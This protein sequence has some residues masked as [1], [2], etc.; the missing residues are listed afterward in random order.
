[1]PTRYKIPGI[2]MLIRWWDGPPVLIIAPSD[3]PIQLRTDRARGYPMVSIP[4]GPIEPRALTNQEKK[5]LLRKGMYKGLFDE[6]RVFAVSDE[7]ANRFE[8]DRKV[9]VKFAAQIGLTED[10]LLR[11][12]EAKRLVNTQQSSNYIEKRA[13]SGLRAFLG[14]ELVK[15]GPGRPS[16]I[17]SEDRAQMHRDAEQLRQDGKTTNQIVRILSQR[18]DVRMSYAKRILEDAHESER[19]NVL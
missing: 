12:T 17:S 15:K 14:C 16:T 5:F 6:Q 19:P 8:A 2:V 1:M 3:R 18:Y 10:D 7:I 13:L 4:R 11:I 9:F